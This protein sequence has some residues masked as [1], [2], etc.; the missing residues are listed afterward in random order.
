[1]KIANFKSWMLVIFLAVVLI[2]QT[3][4]GYGFNPISNPSGDIPVTTDSDAARRYFMAGQDALDLGKFIEARKLFTK[5]VKEDPNFAYALLNIA[6]A[7][8]S[9][10]E[11]KKY[12]EKAA[13]KASYASEGEQL[14]I[15]INQT[16]LDNA[17]EKRLKLAQKLVYKYPNS[18]RAHLA[19]AGVLGNRNEHK[20]ARIAIKKATELQ[21]KL[22]ASY[23][24]MGNSYLFND[25]KDFKRAEEYMAKATEIRPYEAT[26]FI[27]L[28]DV[29]RA[30]KD[31]N[32]SRYAYSKAAEI[33][34]ENA[35]AVLK[36]GHINSFLGNFDEARTDYD[37]ALQLAKEGQKATYANYRAFTYLHEGKPAMAVKEL[38]NIVYNIDN[39]GIPEDQQDGAIIFTLTN[40]AH[41][42]LKNDMLSE[43]RACLDKRAKHLR[44]VADVVGTPEIKATQEANIA[45]W[46][47]MLAAYQG[48]FEKVELINGTK[49]YGAACQ[50]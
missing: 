24:V 7:S 32:K 12:T 18:A 9:F 25:P 30:A 35:I 14:L 21:P 46:E 31:L 11:Y 36:K 43:A 40:Q 28:G 3:Q 10:D 45:I 17:N 19:L 5:A 8:A 13:E 1:M 26:P 42:I 44:H 20:E 37:A 22:I 47:G 4:P 23:L 15:K 6:N 33:D 29:F 50:R 39:M 34:R 16:F 41:I 27:G 38:Q 48:D 2:L 49:K